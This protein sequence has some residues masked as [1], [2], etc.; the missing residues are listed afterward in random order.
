MLQAEITSPLGIASDYL[1]ERLADDCKCESPHSAPMLPCSVEVS[2]RVSLCAGQFLVC[3]VAASHIAKDV[4]T[5]GFVPCP[6]CHKLIADD[7]SVVP[8]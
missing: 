5:T 2:H 4:A 6:F 8:V 3:Q 7:W 1:E